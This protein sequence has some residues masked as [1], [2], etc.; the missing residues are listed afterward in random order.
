MHRCF[1]IQEL[2]V[3]IVEECAM[4]DS[5]LASLA[6]TCT[7]LCEPALNCLWR[8]HRGLGKLVRTLPSHLWSEVD[9]ELASVLLCHIGRCESSSPKFTRSWNPRLILMIGSVSIITPLGSSNSGYLR[10]ITT[11]HLLSSERSPPS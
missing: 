5:T 4:R 6:R 8:E 11:T 9:G 10:I 3:Q 2:V 7:A 1:M